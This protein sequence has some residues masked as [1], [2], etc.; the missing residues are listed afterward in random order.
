MQRADIV[1]H[2]CQGTSPVG[3]ISSRWESSVATWK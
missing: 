3:C 1:S 2:L